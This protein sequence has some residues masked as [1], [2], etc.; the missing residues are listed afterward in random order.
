MH[1]LLSSRRRRRASSV[2]TGKLTLKLGLCV[3]A[4]QLVAGPAFAQAAH[5]APVVQA[6]AATTVTPRITES[7]NTRAIAWG[8]KVETKVSTQI[9]ATVS[10]A[11][12]ANRRAKIIAEA[13]R[14][15][16]A[17]YVFGAAGPKTFDC[18]GFTMYVY[19][20]AVGRSLPHKANLQQRYGKAVSKSNAK[21]GDLIIIRSGS[22]GTHAGIY[23]GNGKMWAAPRTGKTVAVQKIWTS[24][25][26]VRRL[27]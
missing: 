20:K 23:A 27:V 11:A 2:G 13:K 16:G 14:H 19:R 22:Y 7:T 9:K 25:Y 24:S 12:V 18:S 21:P 6:A 8:T 3:V 4:G 15:K 17:P 26:V 1:G 10:K 5:A